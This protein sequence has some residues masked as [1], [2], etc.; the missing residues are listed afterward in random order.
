MFSIDLYL[1]QPDAFLHLLIMFFFP[2]LSALALVMLGKFY[3]LGRKVTYLLGA[4]VCLF[5]YFLAG[6]V[7]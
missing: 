1:Q 3:F 6:S 4:F 5:V 7:L 2:T